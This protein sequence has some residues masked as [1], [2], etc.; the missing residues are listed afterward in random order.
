MMR[1]RALRVVSNHEASGEATMMLNRKNRSLS[2]IFRLQRGGGN[3]ARHRRACRSARPPLDQP[4]QR[5]EWLDRH[6]GLS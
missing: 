3:L 6:G 1:S 2:R 5:I 4:D